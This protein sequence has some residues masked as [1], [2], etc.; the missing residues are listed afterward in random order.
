VQPIF[1]CGPGKKKAVA[2][3]GGLAQ[4]L[5]SQRDLDDGFGFGR[6]GMTAAVD[7]I[8]AVYGQ[9]TC[10]I[11]AIINAIKGDMTGG[12]LNPNLRV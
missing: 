6:A 11:A 12:M 7:A 4:V 1:Q 9:Q 8:Y 3:S 10:V 5:P 2:E